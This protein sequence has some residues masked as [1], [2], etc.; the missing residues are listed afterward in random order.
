L[1][2]K[3]QA[4]RQEITHQAASTPRRVS[5]PSGAARHSVPSAPIETDR[6]INKDPAS[7]Q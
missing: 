6:Q 1:S 2:E 4:D 5:H 7:G 3:E